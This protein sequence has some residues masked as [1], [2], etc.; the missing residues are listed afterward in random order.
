LSSALVIQFLGELDRIKKMSG[1]LNE[2]TIRPAFRGMLRRWSNSEG[3][4]LLEEHEFETKLKTR[5]YPDGTI[6]HD[7]R[8]PLG[9]WEAKD[10]KD[11]LDAEIADKISKG[12]PTSNII[13]EN[14][15]LAVLYQHGSEVV[16][17]PMQ[18]ADKL[19]RLL[20]LF[21][22]YERPEIA[23]FRKAVEQ[24]KTDLPAV[25]S[26]LRDKIEAAYADNEAFKEDANDFLAHA[27]DTINP[28]IGE[29][30]IREMLIQHIL[31]EEIF[32]HVF[33]E[34]D[35]HRENN[36]AEK[37]YEL[38]RRF[39]RGAVKRE[40]LKALEPYYAAIRSAAASITAHLE[41]QKFLKV[42]YENFYKVYNPKAADRLG[43]VYT[44]NEIVRFMIDGADWLCREHFGRGL[45]DE[46][47]NIL[48][49]C[50]GTGTFIC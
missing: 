16:R 13:F 2:Q 29:A 49:P 30:D 39:F 22:N 40:T 24:F 41:K 48:D 33:N 27:K 32:N 42:I 11:D 9:Y 47:V 6:V 37:L 7:L 31:T 45:I 12:Y 4:F 20:T 8:V 50:T 26:A 10:T 44:P 46:K 5:V 19:S 15:D 35:F 28:T 1:S 21:F 14:S 17:A 3:L 23:D 25:L 18:D 38:E 43:V 34:G 36:I